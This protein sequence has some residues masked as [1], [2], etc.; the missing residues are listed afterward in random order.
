VTR[1]GIPIVARSDGGGADKPIETRENVR[2][3]SVS[4]GPGGAHWLGDDVPTPLMLNGR[5]PSTESAGVNTHAVSPAS[6]A[7]R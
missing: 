3:L 6:I 4:R 2:A 7:V 5:H 1:T